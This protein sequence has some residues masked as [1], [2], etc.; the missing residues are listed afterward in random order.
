VELGRDR[1]DL[2]RDAV[3]RLLQSNVVA[4]AI[5][6]ALRDELFDVLVGLA[7]GAQLLADLVIGDL[8]PELVGDSLEHELAR[9]RHRGF[10]AQA[11][12]ERLR[13]LAGQLEI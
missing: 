4:D 3:E 2:G 11:L 12:L 10:G 8:D 5:C 9:D 7:G 6:A 13:R 1:L